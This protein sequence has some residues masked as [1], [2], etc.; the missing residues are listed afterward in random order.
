MKNLSISNIIA[1]THGEYHGDRAL[2]DCVIAGIT[3]DSRTVGKSFLFAAIKG[4][5]VDGHDFIGK[6]ADAGVLV[7]LA[8]RVPEGSTL[9]VIVV[10]NTIEALG[11]LAAFYRRQ[12]DIPVLGV[13]G[14]VGKTT[15]KEMISAVLSQ[16][17]KVHKTAKNLNNDL[18]A[19]LTLFGLDE[20]TE[21][22]VVEMGISHF[23]EMT[24]LAQIVA[25]DMA[26]YTV[27][28][29][30]HLE[31]LG[32]YDGVLRAKTE[33][34]DYLPETGTVFLNGDDATLNKVKCKQT[35]CRYG[36]SGGCDVRAENVRLLGTDGM[37]LDIV[38]AS[39][40]IPAKIN[41][42]GVHMVTAAL[43]AAAVGMKMGLTDAEIAAG[44][45]A[46]VPVGSRSGIISTGC[47]TVIDDCYNANPTSVAAALD[48][49][50]LLPGRHVCI[51]GDMNE[52]GESAEALHY[53]TG[54]HAAKTGVSLVIACGALA[55]NIAAGADGTQA[56]NTVW[57]ADKAQLISDLPKLV[58]KGDAVLVKAS[59]SHAFEDL[60]EALKKLEL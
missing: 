26:L 2:L 32:D 51:L 5:K 27:I 56:E 15:A 8:E 13:T 55:R 18:G 44:I 58:Q 6:A 49:L 22:A 53:Q 34:L 36:V 4:E 46:Y 43:G 11:D 7:A 52:L 10:R 35:V 41:A 12:F 48:S 54:E 14:S 17:F 47:L 59:H 45:A 24:R 20:T 37:A 1:A 50:A 16:R 31:F 39:R 60:V 42:Y 38:S 21:F 23:G 40:R 57:Y 9:P 3:T 28:G 19:P 29:S 33:M 30:A 25:P